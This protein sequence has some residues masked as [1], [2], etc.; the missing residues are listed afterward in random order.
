MQHQDQSEILRDALDHLNQ[1]VVLLDQEL[2][3]EFMNRLAEDLFT[4]R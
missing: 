2:R 1:G 3:V 4:F